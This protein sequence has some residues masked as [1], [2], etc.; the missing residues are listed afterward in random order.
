MR[1]ETHLIQKTPW[2]AAKIKLINRAS[3]EDER[4]RSQKLKKIIILSMLKYK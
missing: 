4:I 2:K 3:H 1:K